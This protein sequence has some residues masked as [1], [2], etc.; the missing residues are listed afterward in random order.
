MRTWLKYNAVSAAGF[1]LQLTLLGLLTE[2]A[3]WRVAWA[4]VAAVEFTTS[5]GTGGGRSRAVL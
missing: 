5:Y 1:V 2:A 3:H 4:T